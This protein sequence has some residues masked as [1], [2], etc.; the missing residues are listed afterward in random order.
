[1]EEE[2]Y[3]K[4]NAVRLMGGKKECTGLLCATESG[5]NASFS[6]GHLG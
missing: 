3:R 1:M 4:K 2:R 5:E 6:Y